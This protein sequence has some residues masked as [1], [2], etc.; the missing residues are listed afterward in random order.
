MSVIAYG[1]VGMH[2]ATSAA[3]TTLLIYHS[4]AFY[5][6]FYT[7]TRD[8]VSHLPYLPII[9]KDYKLA[10]WATILNILATTIY[11]ICSV[12]RATLTVSY[13]ECQWLATLNTIS[14]YIAKF[15]TFFIFSLR[16][17]MVYGESSYKYNPLLLK[18]VLLFITL[19]LFG[20][21]IIAQVLTLLIIPNR[22]EIS[23]DG[24]TI[25]TLSEWDIIYMKHEQ[26]W[27]EL[28]ELYLPPWYGI[29]YITMDMLI[30]I[31]YCTLFVIPIRKVINNMD[32]GNKKDGKKLSSKLI[33]VGFKVTILTIFVFVSTVVTT[34]IYLTT[35]LNTWSLD[36]FINA[37]SLAFMTP[38]YPDDK[39]Y[40]K[41][42][43]C[44]IY[45][46][47]L[48]CESATMIDYSNQAKRKNQAMG[49]QS[50][51]NTNFQNASKSKS[52]QNTKSPKKSFATFKRFTKSFNISLNSY[53][54][55]HDASKKGTLDLTNVSSISDVSGVNSP[56]T[57]SPGGVSTPPTGGGGGGD[58]M[59]LAV[60]PYSGPA[61]TGQEQDDHHGGAGKSG[62]ED[63]I[64]G[65]GS[66]SP[67]VS[68]IS[69]D[70]G[71]NASGSD[72]NEDN[73]NCEENNNGAV[74]DKKVVSSDSKF[75]D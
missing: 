55:D 10:A 59:H 24:T 44:C 65:S 9:S 74:T 22:A 31:F 1:S 4:R 54:S 58:G 13:I 26:S 29:V 23:E 43:K 15:L 52:T 67:A 60:S 38:Y 47:G 64:I 20:F 37:L 5:Q 50:T 56:T 68:N 32:M 72:M 39:Y 69:V 30:N 48:F 61:S 17:H 73:D 19:Y 16:L 70:V 51:T 25:L 42:C 18:T 57:P 63:L 21:G 35:F 45:I 66:D 49:I 41:V 71:P 33:A 62:S 40:G 2:L 6:D 14:F 28:C 53:R 12:Y 8:S 34:I 36:M 27:I 7:K 75:M 46:S 11:A 3:V